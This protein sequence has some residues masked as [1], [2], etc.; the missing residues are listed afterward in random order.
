[1][2][3]V[4]RFKFKSKVTPSEMTPSEMTP[5]EVT[6]SEVTPREG[7]TSLFLCFRQH[8]R[9]NPEIILAK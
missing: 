8:Y 6:P 9:P 7:V 1:M 2:E 5:S 3:K 4:I